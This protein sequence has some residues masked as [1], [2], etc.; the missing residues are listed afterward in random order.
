MRTPD[1]HGVR[2]H[3]ELLDGL[4][5]S[6]TLRFADA[7]RPW[8]PA[9]PAPGQPDLGRA[10]LD[11]YACALHV[12]WAYQ[13]AWADEGF[14][15]TA[16]LPESGGRLLELV[17]CRPRP[18]LAATGLQHFRLKDGTATTIPPG[19][20]VAAPAGGGAPAATYETLRPL[21]ASAALNELRPFLPPGPAPVP[22]VGAIA[23][24]LALLGEDVRVPPTAELLGS[25]SVAD[26]L[27]GRLDGAAAHSQR[28][29]AR[30]RAKAL[31]L[32]AV[33][34]DLAD[35]GAREA[36][37]EMFETLCAELCRQA[38][39]VTADPSRVPAPRSESAELVIGQLARLRRR[40]PEA[41]AALE[42][43]LARGDGEA[44]EAWSFRLDALAA[45][46]D[47]FAGSVLQSARDDVVRLRG[48]RALA[49]LD[50][51]L[52]QG[53]A[54]AAGTAA[55]G[56]D[57]LYLFPRIDPT[58]GPVTQAGLL[59]P[60]DWLV[61]AEDL[62]E[63]GPTGT[64]V[65]RRRARE[66]VQVLRAGDEVPPGRR[67]P[68]TRIVFAPPVRG[69]YDL[70]TTVLLGNVVEISHGRSVVEELPGDALGARRLAEGPLTWLRDRSAPEGRT[71][72]VTLQVA[73][74]QWS[75]VPDLLD[76]DAGSRVFAVD[77]VDAADGG[78]LVRTGDGVE[79]AVPPPRAR[80][81]LG[82]RVG[83]GPDGNRASGAITELV[84]ANPAL[85][86]TR[87][88]LE[89]TGGSAAEMPATPGGH[90]LDRA[91]SE[92]D[93]ASLALTFGGVLRVAVFRDPVR[94]RRHLTVVVSGPGGAAISGDGHR[95][96]AAFLLARLPPG[97]TLD[98]RDRTLVGI[99]AQL[100]VGVAAGAD[101]LA[102]VNEVTG[103]LGADPVHGSGLLH[104]DR[105]ELGRDVHLSDLY[106]ALAGVPGAAT[107]LVRALHRAETAS[108]RRSRIAVAPAELALWAPE[109]GNGPALD[110]QWEPAVD[111]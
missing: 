70:A 18:A 48:P 91:V 64:P 21:H 102:V 60:G 62:G 81:R 108:E 36:C 46:L 29:A 57:T 4:T 31:Q 53:Q 9:A 26:Q 69:R 107:V 15:A 86:A 34:R 49:D 37:P 45:F 17:G 24:L 98:T 106:G 65:T 61:L 67:E 87:N 16:R 12:L 103:R 23:D 76:S 97:T 73:D 82:Y 83:A 92:A 25:S 27:G 93:V 39:A 79:G 35:T 33:A 105:A 99:R 54:P 2:G 44:D 6:A 7:R 66:A 20:A 10:L 47:A 104:P 74:L 63:P 14:L 88:P 90:A 56:A 89:V 78:A 85:A 43:A 84:G 80:V 41:V 77:A 11:C 95:E 50:A 58:V 52:G 109:T 22:T 71:P 5:A 40:L 28:A 38:Q 94:R 110:V 96:L 13:H 59:R 68:M 1:A 42:S 75:A 8:R 111:R 32:A 19:F 100:V 72:A 3:P 30:A 55:P 101:P 51:A